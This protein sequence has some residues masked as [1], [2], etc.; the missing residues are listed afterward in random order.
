[1]KEKY[2]QQ[3]YEELKEYLNSGNLKSSDNKDRKHNTTIVRFMLDTSKSI[4][5]YCGKMSVFTNSFYQHIENDN[6][7]SPGIG[8]AL[9]EYLIESLENFINREDVN[10]DIIV[11]N[12]EDKIFDNLICKSIFLKGILEKK[13]SIRKIDKQLMFTDVI[14]HSVFTDR[15]T[16][17]QEQNQDKYSGI[18]LANYPDELQKLL[19]SNFRTMTQGSYPVMS[20]V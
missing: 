12:Y 7:D 18:F 6:A 4:K 8:D 2:M 10:L 17:R 5:M 9:K 15:H 16:M 3:Y 20:I 1:M 11:E 13:I 19:E 14:A